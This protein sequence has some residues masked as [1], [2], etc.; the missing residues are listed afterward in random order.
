[1]TEN[2]IILAGNTQIIGETATHSTSGPS[3]DGGGGTARET[4]AGFTALVEFADALGKGIWAHF[5]CA[6]GLRCPGRQKNSQP[7]HQTAQLGHEI[8]G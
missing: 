3:S 2:A 4:A 1:M 7:I 6:L 5:E 8:G